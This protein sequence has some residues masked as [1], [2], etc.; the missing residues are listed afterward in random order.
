MKFRILVLIGFL[1]V[2]CSTCNQQ[3]DG[4]IAEKQ[5]FQTEELARIA[6]GYANKHRSGKQPYQAKA[7]AR[8][9]VGYAKLDQQVIASTLLAPAVQT[10]KVNSSV[11]EQQQM[12]QE[13]GV[14]YVKMERYDQA[15]QAA[16]SLSVQ[17]KEGFYKDTAL[18]E[19]TNEMI[20][21]GQYDRAAQVAQLISRN[22]V[23][24]ESIE[25]E[26]TVSR[27]NALIK[28]AQGLIATKQ[29][30][31]ALL[32][33]A[34]A[35][36]SAKT[37]SMITEVAVEYA[38]VGQK[39]KA[40]RLLS[41]ISQKA[42]SIIAIADLAVKHAQLGQK[43][44]ASRMLARTLQITKNQADKYY[45][46]NNF[47]LF[48]YYELIKIATSYAA[49]GQCS[50]SI[51]IAKAIKA[52][53]N[54]TNEPVRLTS[55]GAIRGTNAVD[56]F[57]K[58]ASKCA[59]IGQFNLA[60][61]AIKESKWIDNKPPLLAQLAVEQATKQQY[62]Q[63]FESLKNVNSNY[64]KAKALIKII[65]SA[66]QTEQT[67][68]VFPVL[69]KAVEAA[70]SINDDESKALVLAAL[71]TGYAEIGKTNQADMMLAQ[72]LQNT[73]KIHR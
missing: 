14:S 11:H 52:Y 27:S 41:Q 65:E 71:G 8:I 72:A 60:L 40:L 43:D 57:A 18:G 36:E 49:I 59:E 37:D 3:L 39:D 13:V 69:M 34:Q 68:R 67:S 1:A 66:I 48:A 7:L 30:K 25:E 58:I 2:G 38:N 54:I 24:L 64:S 35:L 29:N 23:R 33:L 61:Q 45:Q 22:G 42:N 53:P 55:D 15:L 21:A 16:K 31:K 32:I 51:E 28:I 17:V 12:W 10:A 70:K 6:D 46:T 9:A 56:V 63:S 4:S 62:S 26:Y 50:Q 44:K 47:S 73:K 19:I 20:A 5:P